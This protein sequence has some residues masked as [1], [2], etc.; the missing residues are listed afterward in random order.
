MFKK[1]WNP[2]WHKSQRTRIKVT[3]SE[4]KNQLLNGNLNL[5]QLFYLLN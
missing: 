1:E 3:N 2:M 4:D 5:Y